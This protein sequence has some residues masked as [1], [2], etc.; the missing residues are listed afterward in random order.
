[1]SEPATVPLAAVRAMLDAMEA[2]V[3][4]GQRANA[5][6]HALAVSI[7]YAYPPVKALV[8]DISPRSG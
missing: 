8:K 5:R 3:P 2:Y 1:M 4:P 7:A 6:A